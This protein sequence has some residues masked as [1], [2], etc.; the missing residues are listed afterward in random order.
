MGEDLSPALTVRET[1]FRRRRPSKL[2]PQFRGS[3]SRECR[4]DAGR[5]KKYR[6]RR[7]RLR[8]LRK[9]PGSEVIVAQVRAGKVRDRLK[10]NDHGQIQLIAYLNSHVEGGIVE[11][12]FGA[13]HPVNDAF[14]A[15]DGSVWAPH[16][17][18]RIVLGER[19]FG[20]QRIVQLVC[21][22][23][24]LVMARCL[25]SDSPRL[26]RGTAETLRHFRRERLFDRTTK[27]PTNGSYSH[28]ASS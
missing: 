22:E 12:A 23:L 19:L 8:D 17:D 2:R 14:A 24:R 10:V 15:F 16:R 6:V 9:V 21:R 4:E 20:A 25:E 26:E 3:A 5:Q 13:L 11:G 18:S 1:G 28:L 27:D 7:G